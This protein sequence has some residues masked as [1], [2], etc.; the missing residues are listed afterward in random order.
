MG[1]PEPMKK[2][3]VVD[4]SMGWC[5]HRAQGPPFPQFLSLFTGASLSGYQPHS[6]GEKRDP[7]L[8]T[9]GQAVHVVPC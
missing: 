8:G 9:Q 1:H 7:Q 4:M 3:T 2:W 6:L 5:S